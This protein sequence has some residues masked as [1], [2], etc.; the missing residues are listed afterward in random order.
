MRLPQFLATPKLRWRAA[1]VAWMF[2][3]VAILLVDG[4]KALVP[5]FIGFLATYFLLPIVHWFDQQLR[6]VIWRKTLARTLS[7]IVVYVLI[8]CI[9]I[10]FIFTFI[11]AFRDQFG[12]LI[13]SFPSI[14]SRVLQL[15]RTDWPEFMQSV[16]PELQEFVNTN[17]SKAAEAIMSAIQVGLGRTVEIITQTISFVLG[18]LVVPVWVFIVLQDEEK[19]WR[20][21]YHL[22][23][24]K[25]RDDVR[26]LIRILDRVMNAYVR[27][28]VVGMLIIW[29]LTTG[30]FMAMGVDLAILWGAL[31]GLTEVIPIVGPY[32]GVIPPVIWSLAYRPDMAVWII[33]AYVI[34]Q[35]VAGSLIMPHI[36]GNATRIHPAFIMILVLVG[37]EISGF[38]GLLLIVPTT[39]MIRDVFTYLYIR[40]T[41]KGTTPQ[42]AM[43]VFQI[44]IDEHSL[45]KLHLIRG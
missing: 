11:P 5:F 16:P 10:L 36:S 12:A 33:V 3:L 40:T 30:T 1:L 7:I 13:K 29:V 45:N 32:L 17:F 18:A 19:A 39:A 34:V 20:G 23:P 22:I 44:R 28:Q 37:A 27:S 41:D 6:R 26:N 8:I 15:V 21:F 31:A 43:A 24:A 9:T 14:Y 2:I 25:V 35:N 38:W 42:D 4:W